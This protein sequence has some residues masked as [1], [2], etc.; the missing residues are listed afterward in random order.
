MLG[1]FDVGGRISEAAAVGATD[2]RKRMPAALS[3]PQ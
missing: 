1:N 2:A 3:T